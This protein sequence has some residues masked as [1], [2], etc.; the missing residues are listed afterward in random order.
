MGRGREACRGLRP[1]AAKGPARWYWSRNKAFIDEAIASGDEYETGDESFRAGY[2]QGNTFEAATLAISRMAGKKFGVR[3]GRRPLGRRA[4]AATSAVILEGGPVLPG[5][6]EAFAF[7]RD[8]GFFRP[9][10][11]EDWISFSSGDLGLQVIRADDRDGRV[12]TIVPRVP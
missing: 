9:E 12:N 2:S 5:A 10:C 7:V 4:G 11:R 1:A 6:D 3:R 8:V